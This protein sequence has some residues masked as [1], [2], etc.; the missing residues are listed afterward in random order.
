M[1][2]EHADQD[3]VRKCLSGSQEAWNEF[4]SRY[5]RLIK[6]VIR[7]QLRFF[8]EHLEDICQEVLLEMVTALKNYDSSHS[9]TKFVCIVTE[10]VCIDQ[11]RFSNAE[12]RS[13]KTQSLDQ[14][15]SD[16]LESTILVSDDCSPDE[17]VASAQLVHYLR[18]CI[19]RL[20]ARCREILKM[21]Y[22]MNLPFKEIGAAVGATENTVTVQARR[23][24]D[25]LKALYFEMESAGAKP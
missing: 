7:R 21:R 12:K 4:Y 3:L 18:I 17:Q 23:C 5:E 16:H 8:E 6:S 9:L 14:Q 22:E 15:D 25:E 20:S 10:R 1:V 24:M 11:Y 19:R 2:N 13:G